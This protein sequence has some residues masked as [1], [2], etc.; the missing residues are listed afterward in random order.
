MK[1]LACRFASRRRSTSP[2]S[3][4]L[5]IAILATGACATA[6]PQQSALIR[7]A[8]NIEMPTTELRL[9][10]YGYGEEFAGDVEEAADRILKATDDPEVARQA[11]RWKIN[12]LSATQVAAFALDPLIGLYDMWALAVQ[13]RHF[14]ESGPGG[15]VFG[16]YQPIAI[17]TSRELERKADELARSISISGDVSG[18]RRDIDEYAA[19]HPVTEM[20]F[21]R[22]TV[23]KEFADL[24]AQD[25]ASGLA[26]LGD[27]ATQLGD[28]TERLKFY[29]ASMP[30]QFRWQSELLLLDILDERRV[31]EFL[32][33][34]ESIDV[35]ARRLADFADSLPAVI[36][37]QA[38][39]AIRV[40]GEEAAIA[41]RDVNRQR[42]A[43][44]EWLTEERIVVIENLVRERIAVMEDLAAIT[45]SAM[46]RTTLVMDDAVDRAFYRALQLLGLVFVGGLVFVFL[47]R[48]IWK[49]PSAALIAIG[50]GSSGL[51]G[52]AVPA[53]ALAQEAD[54]RDE[55]RVEYARSTAG[56]RWLESERGT[57]IKLLVEAANLGGSEVE[58]GEIT[59]PG[60]PRP[61]GQGHLHGS[62]EIFYVL[63][64]E[65]NHV[66]NGESHLLKPGMVGIV[67]P[68]DR[69][70]HGV[71]STDPVR[72]LVVWAPGGEADRIAPYFDQRPIEPSG[73]P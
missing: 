9:R 64:G 17:E 2:H 5:L 30:H 68:G 15:D 73:S 3:A 22:E 48:L 1:S 51:G 39:E 67:R 34:V 46:R 66:V 32:G 59:F 71:N 57:T 6:P 10:V 4:L 33:D 35:S 37:E 54:A 14:F 72:A 28:M 61:A 36:D 31:D 65:M 44:L 63:S 50:L 56:T 70:A 13:M 49:R 27:L 11:L 25:R 53:T 41:L 38:S 12:I 40:V 42:I 43:T 16:E 55:S 58:I 45:D 7:S 18:P 20:H 8:P 52:S 29:A 62:I 24:L 19:A 60:G 21:V 23:T 47:V 26:V 69:V